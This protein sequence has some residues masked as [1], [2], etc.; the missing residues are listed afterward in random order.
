MLQVVPAGDGLTYAVHH[1]VLKA[2]RHRL[3][4]GLQAAG[5]IARQLE[6]RGDDLLARLLVVVVDVRLGFVQRLER[7][8]ELGLESLEGTPWDPAIGR[9]FEQRLGDG[10]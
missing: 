3:A 7:R 1:S 9:R 5:R 8:V 6:E 10:E 2:V 4:G